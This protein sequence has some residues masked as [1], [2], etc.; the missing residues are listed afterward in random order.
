[1]FVETL[2]FEN[3]HNFSINTSITPWYNDLAFPNIYNL[4]TYIY[5]INHVTPKNV[6]APPWFNAGVYEKLFT[7]SNS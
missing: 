6:Y 1:M 3:V 7:F 2:E 4:T 5:N